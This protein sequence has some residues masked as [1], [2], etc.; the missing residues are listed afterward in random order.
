MI[1]TGVFVLPFVLRLSA[2]TAAQSVALDVYNP[3]GA[4][5]VSFLHA[6]RLDTLEGKTICFMGDGSWEDHRAL[7]LVEKTLKDRF[8]T[9]KFIAYNEF[10]YAKF[11]IDDD[12][13]AA[14]AKQKGCQAVIIGNAA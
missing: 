6:A 11:V 3:S 5:E 14:M 9:A 10:P 12:K 13:V 2:A 4:T 1:L 7:P 8:P